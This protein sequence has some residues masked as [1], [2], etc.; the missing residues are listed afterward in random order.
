MSSVSYLI[1]QLGE[2]TSA[3][4]KV[5]EGAQK[6][7]GALA[8]KLVPSTIVAG[9]INVCKKFDWTLSSKSRDDVPY[10]RLIEY[11]NTE[12]SIKKQFDF[13][14]KVTP[15]SVQAAF[16]TGIEKEGVLYPYQEIFPKD[17]PTD[18]SYWFPYFNDTAYQLNT[19]SWQALDSLG[20]S[21]K[22]LASGLGADFISKAIDFG[23]AATQTAMNWQ[24]AGVG[25]FDRPKIFAGHSER[26]I[27]IS[28]PLFNTAR[29]DALGQN[30]SLI[31]L[32]MSQNLYNKRDYVTGMPPVFYEVFIPGQYFCY[33]A[34]MTDID[35]KNL[36]NVRLMGGG[37]SEEGGIIAPD[38][39]QVTLT[40]SE[41]TMPS[42]NQFSAITSGEA[43][44]FVNTS[45]VQ[46][47]RAQAAA[48]S[49]VPGDQKVMPPTKGIKSP[50][51]NKNK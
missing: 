43:R 33:A 42:K 50:T 46:S 37:G 38:A 48:E 35:V 27:T 19:P 2:L 17:N 49:S 23:T 7:E 4:E 40:L 30:R 11:Y 5:A 16:G 13:Y 41:M 28:F 8:P 20:E 25:T 47:A 31:Q 26:Q 14:G 51:R 44:K 15:E 3:T 21:V 22:N 6:R 10:I 39:Y 45:T 34:S 1:N 29:E 24:Y 36:G 32:L 12:T 9:Q 18:Y